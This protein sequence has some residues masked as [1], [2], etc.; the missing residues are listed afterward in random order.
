[1]LA[2]LDSVLVSASE[3][4]SAAWYQR[5]PAV[6]RSLGWR[7]LIAHR[8]LRRRWAKLAAEYRAA[9]ADF[10]SPERWRQ[11]FEASLGRSPDGL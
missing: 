8:R 11:T 4:T 9:A 1:V 2:K 5:D 3:G 7:S 6:F 10:N